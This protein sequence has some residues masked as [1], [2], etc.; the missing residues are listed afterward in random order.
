MIDE[1]LEET[2]NH[3]YSD[4]CVQDN[5]ELSDAALIAMGR[6]SKRISRR[7]GIQ[8]AGA[9]CEQTCKI[10]YNPRFVLKHCNG[11]TLSGRMIEN[12]Q[13]A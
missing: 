12:Y 11:R 2:G 6:D 4:I 8:P 3:A 1:K 9:L 7:L 10:H 13:A 5:F